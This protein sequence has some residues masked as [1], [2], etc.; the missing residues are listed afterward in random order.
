M[1]NNTYKDKTR[2]V[3]RVN[4]IG[5][6]QAQAPRLLPGARAAMCSRATRGSRRL[7]ADI[8]TTTYLYLLQW[9]K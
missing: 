5:Q 7:F 9:I 3:Q 1:L 4:A 2:V 8:Y 6:V